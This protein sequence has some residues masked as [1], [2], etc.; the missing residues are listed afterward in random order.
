MGWWAVTWSPELMSL[1][2]LHIM[3]LV[4]KLCIQVMV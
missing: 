4:I 2:Q 1:L 3:V